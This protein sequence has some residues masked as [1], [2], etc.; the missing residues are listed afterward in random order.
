MASSTDKQPKRTFIRPTVLPLAFTPAAP[1]I[2]KAGRFVKAFLY[3]DT[4]VPFEDKRATSV[5]QKVSMDYGPD[6][7]AHMGDLLDCYSL[8]RYDKNPDRKETLQDEIDMAR[9]HLAQLRD[10]HPNARIVYLEGNHEDRL[11][12][13]LW[14]LEGPAAV[15][16]QLTAFKKYITWPE[17]LGLRS[18]HIEFIPYAEQSRKQILPKFILK[19]GTVVRARSAYTANGEWSKYGRSGASGHTH[20]LGA[21]FHRDHNG[22]H[23]WV[24]TGCTCRLD[25]EYTVDPDWQQGAVA[26][27]FD[28]KTGAPNFQ[29]IYVHNGSTVW[30]EQWYEVKR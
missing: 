25:P 24:E 18:L 19:H 14:N 29:P 2:R 17:L 5:V 9:N 23:G 10:L 20:R 4:H 6:I 21:F 27:T 12:R 8:S 13:L 28:T 11:R 26:I 22:N 3:G 15:L 16:A 7:I 1:A 30:R